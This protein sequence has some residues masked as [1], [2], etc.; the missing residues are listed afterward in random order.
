MTDSHRNYYI[1]LFYHSQ[2]LAPSRVEFWEL[3]PLLVSRTLKSRVPTLLFLDPQRGYVTVYWSRIWVLSSPS[4]GRPLATV[5]INDCW[6]PC[7]INLALGAT[8]SH[9]D[10][11][12]GFPL[13]HSQISTLRSAL[14]D[15]HSQIDTLRSAFSD[16]HSQISIL[17]S[18]LS[19]QHSQVSTV[20]SAFSDQHSQ[21]S[22]VRS[23]FSDQHCQIST[24]RSALSDQHSQ[25]RT[26][27]YI[28]ALRYQN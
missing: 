28:F 22:T 13:R 26:E 15:Q 21:I 8:S 20:R 7:F 23:A 17:R 24:L 19:D 3:F 2:E 9:S 12:V 25:T 14:S 1:F 18:A 11:I 4:E 5:I 16:Q 10:L 27:C 6:I